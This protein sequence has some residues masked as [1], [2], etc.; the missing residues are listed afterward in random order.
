[1][2]KAWLTPIVALLLAAGLLWTM[3]P[4]LYP[5]WAEGE[6]AARPQVLAGKEFS[7]IVA[8]AAAPEGDAMV[9]TRMQQGEAV[10]RANPR[11][12]AAKYPQLRL[13]LD[14]VHPGLRLFLFWRVAEAPAQQRVLQL[15]Q[16]SDGVR[17]YSLGQSELWQGTVIEIAVGAFGEPGPAPLRLQEAAFHGATRG[18]LLA[19]LLTEWTSDQ[20]W[21]LSAMNLQSGIPPEGLAHPNA[22]AA[23]GAACG[24]LVL[25]WAALLLRLPR[26]ALVAGV[27]LLLFLP[28]LLLDLLWQGQ[29]NARLAFSREQFG[30][31]DQQAK[32]QREMDAALFNYARELS[33]LLPAD[34]GRRLFLLHGSEGHNFQRLRLQYHLLPLNVYNFGSALLPPGEMRPGDYLLQFGPLERLRYDAPSGVLEDDRQRWQAHL[35]DQRELGRLFRL[36]RPLSPWAE[37]QR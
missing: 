6:M 28:W 21:R 31:L 25:A 20:P 12:A 34:P 14:G 7:P 18:A 35:L 24:L 37:A 17:W 5:D 1:M 33:A 26:R 15:E 32:H 23:L 36:V 29:L 4:L 16:H 11:F 9:I 30:G 13:H 8:A 22:V 3:L 27:L 2:I 10:F 19:R